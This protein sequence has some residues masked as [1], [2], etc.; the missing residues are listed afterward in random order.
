MF[1]RKQENPQRIVELGEDVLIDL[2][3]ISAVYTK[4][5]YT[6][7]IRIGGMGVIELGRD[8]L[9]NNSISEA[10]AKIRKGLIVK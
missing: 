1:G 9:F 4:G 7:V 2:N 6:L 8:Q 3:Q 5:S 10:Y